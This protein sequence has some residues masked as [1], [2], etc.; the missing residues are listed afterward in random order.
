[1]NSDNRSSFSNYGKCVDIFAPGE[2]ITSADYKTTN[3]STK[4]SGTSMATPHVSGVAA[5][6]LSENPSA[7]PAQ[8]ADALKNWAVQGK[9]TNTNGSPNLLLQAPADGA[10]TPVN[11]TPNPSPTPTPTPTPTPI[12]NPTP[13][14]SAAIVSMNI[15]KLNQY[16][17]MMYALRTTIS[18]KDANGNPLKRY[19][20]NAK[21]EGAL[22]TSGTATTNQNGQVTFTSHVLN[23]NGQTKITV[24]SV[25]DPNGNNVSF[26]GDTSKSI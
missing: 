23:G 1:M 18:L 16:G 5:R 19:R 12:T 10:S 25:T 26:S 3:G 20:I 8:V 24:I 17:N 22:N 7:T 15:Q 4:M 6:Y 2:N 11:P 21:A 13:T 14:P 9:V